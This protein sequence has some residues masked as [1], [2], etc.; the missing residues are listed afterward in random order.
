MSK[1]VKTSPYFEYT[2]NALKRIVTLTNIDSLSNTY[3]CSHR[4]YWLY[5]TSD[6]ADSVRNFSSHTFALASIHPN[7]DADEQLFFAELAKA[8]IQFWLSIQHKDGSFDEFYPYERGWVGPTA[9]TIYSNI[10]AFFLVSD[11]FSKSEKENFLFSVQK[12]TEYIIKGDREGDYLANHHAMAYLALIKS[13]KLLEDEFILKGALKSYE[14]YLKY[15]NNSDGWSKEYDGIDPGY[16]TA[17]CSFFA[18]TLDVYNNN[19]VLDL[20]KTYAQT[21]SAF[22]FPDGSFSGPIGSR[23]TMHLYPFAFEYLY[24]ESNQ[25]SEIAAFSQYSLSTGNAITP[26]IMS[27]RYV[28]YRV[29]EYLVTDKLFIEGKA[30]IHK[31]LNINQENLLNIYN[32]GIYHFRSKDRFLTVNYAKNI[33]IE[34]FNY[35]EQKDKWIR[36]AFT[37]VHILDKKGLYSSQYA[38]QNN[39][40]NESSENIIAKGYLHKVPSENAFNLTKNIIFRFVL[41]ICSKST[42]LSNYLKRMIR[43]NLMYADESKLY[44]FSMVF[45]IKETLLEV[46][47][48]SEKKS[49]PIKIKLSKRVSERYVPQS[50]FSRNSDIIIGDSWLSLKEES[51]LAKKLNK[52]GVIEYKLKL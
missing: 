26:D 31:Q 44:K 25:I 20:I 19:E 9:F 2:Q 41:L 30:K 4:D 49:F 22:C 17:T 51:M 3:G 40:I 5:K 37:G 29:E 48:Y 45:N 15:Y 23:N 36:A 7:H 38:N 46:K 32:A 50:R 12:S 39:R 28:H 35:N 42:Y 33:V 16:L 24:K 21:I 27:D 8:S 13:Y 11:L 14:N 52:E 47:V 1:Q 10:E 6:F 18:K 43:K 34:S